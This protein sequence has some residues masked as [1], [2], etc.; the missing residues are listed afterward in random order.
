MDAHNSSGKPDNTDGTIWDVHPGLVGWE[1]ILF[2]PRSEPGGIPV[3][4]RSRKKSG[5]N[6]LVRGLQALEVVRQEP[7][8]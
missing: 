1:R 4:G 8:A 2:G 5:K 6:A 7:V 3:D